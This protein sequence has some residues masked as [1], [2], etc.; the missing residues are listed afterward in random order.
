MSRR[1]PKYR[2]IPT[3]Q[4][5]VSLIESMVALGVF[6]FGIMGV[7]ILELSAVR[8][9]VAAA[10]VNLATTLA[11]SHLELF[12]VAA[13]DSLTDGQATYD[14]YGAVAGPSPYFYVRWWVSGVDVKDVVVNV[15]WESHD[16][17][18]QHAIELR[19]KVVR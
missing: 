8:G 11:N 1:L 16:G 10:N 12:A 5:G 2:S 13:F 9:G 14:R 6:A 19:T 15:R 17:Q 7:G 3:S 4:R 18:R